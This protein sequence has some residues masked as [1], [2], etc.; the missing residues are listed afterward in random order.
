MGETYGECQKGKYNRGSK[1]KER[2]RDRGGEI[3]MGQ[4]NS[5]FRQQINHREGKKQ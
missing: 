3:K 1:R 5:A 4:K 2:H